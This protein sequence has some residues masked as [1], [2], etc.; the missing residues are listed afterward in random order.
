[1][2]LRINKEL[3]RVEKKEKIVNLFQYPFM[4]YTKIRDRKISQFFFSPKNPNVN[5][6][7]TSNYEHNSVGTNDDEE[8]VFLNNN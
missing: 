2:K 7:A 5:L 8:D 1:M 4:D 6:N 3:Q